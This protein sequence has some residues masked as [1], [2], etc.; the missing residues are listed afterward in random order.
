MLWL[1]VCQAAAWACP[2]EGGI[3]VSGRIIF[4]VSIRLATASF[5]GLGARL[6]PRL[7]RC[8]PPTAINR[9]NQA[10]ATYARVNASK[11]RK[12]RPAYVPT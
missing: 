9:G 5:L 11:K 7:C 4:R 12:R 6:L 10:G 8:V 1:I 2:G 3:H